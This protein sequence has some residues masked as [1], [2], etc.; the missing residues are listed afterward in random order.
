[1]ATKKTSTKIKS[2]K[3]L[4]AKAVPSLSVMMNCCS[5]TVDLILHDPNVKVEQI[6]NTVRISHPTDKFSI[7]GL[8]HANVKKDR[9][10]WQVHLAK[11]EA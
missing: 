7:V 9:K 3:T 4:K 5:A 2:S 1:M 10:P 6:G 11:G 8:P